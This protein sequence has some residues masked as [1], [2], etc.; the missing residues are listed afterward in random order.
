MPAAGYFSMRLGLWPYEIEVWR[1]TRRDAI[2]DYLAY[3]QELIQLSNNKMEGM[4]NQRS[5]RLPVPLDEA[6]LPVAV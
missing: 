6:L 1:A 3:V 2:P 4:R 5:A